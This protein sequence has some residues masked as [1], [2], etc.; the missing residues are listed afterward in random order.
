[1]ITKRDVRALMLALELA[2]EA[3]ASGIVAPSDQW[4][5]ALGIVV[6]LGANRAKAAH[7]ALKDTLSAHASRA[8]D[9]LCAELLA[10]AAEM[11]A[12]CEGEP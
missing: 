3:N 8:M 9:L 11:L 4:D 1:M 6:G 2:R 7:E 5:T 12:H 10:D